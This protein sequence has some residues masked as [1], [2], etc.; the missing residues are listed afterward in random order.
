MTEKGGNERNDMAKKKKDRI[1]LRYYEIPQDE[2]VL[3]LPERERG[4]EGAGHDCGGERPGLH[5]HNLMEIRC[6]YDGEK[7]VSDPGTGQAPP[8]QRLVVFPGNYPHTADCAEETGHGPEYLYVDPSELIAQMYPKD[9]L[10]QKEMLQFISRQSCTL[11]EEEAPRL[12]LLIRMIRD[13][14]DVRRPHY[15]ASVR[16]LL[17]AAM[18]ELLRL[19]QESGVQDEDVS[20]SEREASGVAQITGALEF[21]RTEYMNSIRVANLAQ[22]CRMSETHF[23][24]VFEEAMNMQPVDYINLVRIQNACEL[25]K[26]T[27][28]SMDTIAKKVGFTTPSTFNRNFKKFLKTSP[29]QWKLN[30]D[31]YEGVSHDYNHHCR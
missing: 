17:L 23:R 19:N 27:D 26:K 4:R 8:F 25:M 2:Y 12:F 28:E 9:R 31:Q 1:E 13:E 24:R 29:Y 22:A 10:R 16:G 15:T 5:F 20:V 30:P 11:R 3:V 6:C 18:S 21:V 7:G 14:L